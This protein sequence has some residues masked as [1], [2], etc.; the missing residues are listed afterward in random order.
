MNST[1]PSLLIENGRATGV[2][3]QSG[4]TLRAEAEV[5]VTSGAF[6]SAKLLIK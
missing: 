2:V 1:S 6:G 4:E 5:I 3:L